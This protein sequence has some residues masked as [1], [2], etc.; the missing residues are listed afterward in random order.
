[1]Y[2][3]VKMFITGFVCSVVKIKKK[4]NINTFRICF[5]KNK[6]EAYGRLNYQN[7]KAQ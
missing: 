3:P 6:I 4:Y 2:F 7:S 1:M 5:A